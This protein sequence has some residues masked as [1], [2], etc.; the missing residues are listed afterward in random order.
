MYSK[1][2]E[3]NETIRRLEVLLADIDGIGL[4]PPSTPDDV[5]SL[6]ESAIGR[7]RGNNSWIAKIE[8]LAWKIT[9]PFLDVGIRRQIRIIRELA[10]TLGWG[11]KLTEDAILKLDDLIFQRTYGRI[12]EAPIKRVVR[13]MASSGAM[14]AHEL[15]NLVIGRCFRVDANGRVTVPDGKGVFSLGVVKIL[16]AVAGLTTPI[17]ILIFSDLD[18]KFKLLGIMVYAAPLMLAYW[19]FARYFFSPH[20]LI[21]RVQKLLP[22]LQVVSD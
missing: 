18:F 8:R 21:P 15:K 4:S 9:A 22:R 16:L 20:R 13:S 10:N 12:V 1:D 7:S 17:S 3:V 19:I 6:L 14:G 2:E 5:L 11:S